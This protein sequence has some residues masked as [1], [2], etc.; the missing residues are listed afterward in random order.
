MKSVE[1]MRSLLE[2]NSAEIKYTKNK[3]LQ[4]LTDIE[5][6]IGS[7]RAIISSL[8]G[9]IESLELFYNENDDNRSSDGAKAIL[10]KIEKLRGKLDALRASSGL[11]LDIKKDVRRLK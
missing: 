3:S 2:S 6:H 7:A 8:E 4:I 5:D 11:V 10:G 1:K 9:Y